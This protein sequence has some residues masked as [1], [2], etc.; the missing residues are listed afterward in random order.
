MKPVVRHIIVD[1]IVH[2]Q[3][4]IVTGR[5]IQRMDMVHFRPSNHP[6]G[7]QNTNACDSIVISVF[8][9]TI[10]STI[11]AMFANGN[12]SMMGG[13]EDPKDGKK[14]AAAVFGAVIVYAVSWSP[15]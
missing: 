1:S 8:A 14:V 12:H 4:L 13:T 11:G 2:V 15:H 7:S 10:L 9:I 3:W 6:P 5:R